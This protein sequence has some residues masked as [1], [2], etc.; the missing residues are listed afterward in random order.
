MCIRDRFFVYAIL[1]GFTFSTLFLVYDVATMVYVFGLTALYF[2]VLAAYG[3]FTKRDLTG[4]RSFLFAGL[5]FLA[6]YWIIALFLPMAMFDKVVC[7]IGLAVF[8]GYTAYDTQMIKRYHAA[9]LHDPDMA[10]KGAIL[11][12]LQLYLDLSLIHIWRDESS[13]G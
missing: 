8:M 4:L 3:H 11:C 10:H 5:I 7:F 1:N 2:G 13:P 9:T 6:L 12:A